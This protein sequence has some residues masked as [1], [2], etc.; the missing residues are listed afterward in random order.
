MFFTCIICI[1]NNVAGIFC[2]PLVCAARA[3]G[4]LPFKTEQVLKKVIAPLCRCFGPGNF[5]S[6]GDRVGAFAAAIAVAPAKTL[7]L[8][9][10]GF[11]LFE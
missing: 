4:K 7:R 6:A 11:G 5:Q 2:Y 10:G 9:T 8:D 3:L 1:R